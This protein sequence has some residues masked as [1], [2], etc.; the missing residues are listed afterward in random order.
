VSAVHLREP[1]QSVLQGPFTRHALLNPMPC[2]D[3]VHIC[4]GCLPRVTRQTDFTNNSGALAY[5]VSEESDATRLKTY[6]KTIPE[7]AHLLLEHVDDMR[8][9][10]FGRW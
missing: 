10:F 5:D 9:S 2:N 7:Q 3:K 1:E 8:T 4:V 6:L